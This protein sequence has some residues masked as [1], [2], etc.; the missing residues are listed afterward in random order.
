MCDSLSMGR[1]ECV[2][3]FDCVSK[4]FLVTQGATFK[5]ILQCFAFQVLQNQEVDSAVMAYIVKRA[6]MGMRKPRD[7]S[8]F[9]LESLLQIWTLA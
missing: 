7:R 1:I 6:N 5:P 9:L 4:N 3:Y 2:C 8:C